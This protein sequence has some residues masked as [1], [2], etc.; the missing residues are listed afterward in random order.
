MPTHSYN[1]PRR[2]Q[3]DIVHR[4]RSQRSIVY[5]FWGRDGMKTAIVQACLIVIQLQG[6]SSRVQPLAKVTLLS[7]LRSR[8][9][10]KL[11]IREPVRSRCVD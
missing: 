9:T 2:L 11:K 3:R 8:R 4:R 5:L 1:M 10:A 6:S 7:K